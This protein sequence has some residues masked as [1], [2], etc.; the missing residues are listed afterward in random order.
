[1]SIILL[2]YFMGILQSSIILKFKRFLPIKAES[3]EISLEELI[4]QRINNIY[5]TD[6]YIGDPPQ[7]IPG[8]LKNHE[9]KFL[10]SNNYC[11]KKEYYYK[12]KSKTFSYNT[13]NHIGIQITDTLLFPS[14]NNDIKIE[15]STIVVDN[16]MK[17]PQ[18]FHIGTQLLMKSEEK[19]T[20]FMD[21]LYKKKYLTSYFYKFSIINEDELYLVL[22]LDIDTNNN[23]NYKFIN[24]LVVK[25]F[26]NAPNYQKWGL[27]FDSFRLNNDKFEYDGIIKAE[28]DINYRCFLGTSDFKVD[29]E[30]YLKKNEINVDEKYIDRENYIFYFDKNTKG[31]EELKKFELVFY[32][33]ELNF[34]FTFNFDDLFLEKNNGFYFLI[35]FDYITR[36]EWK[37]GFPFF[38]KYNFIFNYNSKIM[39]FNYQNINLNDDD[40]NYKKNE[41]KN[42]KNKNKI[43]IKYIFIIVFGIIILTGIILLL[44]ILIGKKI[45]SVRKAKVNELLELYDYTSKRIENQNN[46]DN[47]IQQI[48]F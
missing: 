42:Q 15:N 5:T 27:S 7:L 48:F 33:R 10:L 3:K 30:K 41:K 37:L 40:I 6:I 25:I 26:K 39:G 46:K 45:F 32:H 18:C 28:F 21:L 36:N 22:N 13:S 14:I 47:N 16:D 9:H 8:F 34:N 35:F 20:N 31:I 44:G 1:M 4:N 2:F 23:N 24:P 17:S 43:N 12:E 11:P 19:K 38:K 29:F